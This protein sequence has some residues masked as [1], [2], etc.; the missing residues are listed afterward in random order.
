MRAYGTQSPILGEG[1]MSII[2]QLHLKRRHNNVTNPLSNAHKANT[3]SCIKVDSCK[4]KMET[5]PFLKDFV[6]EL[7]TKNLGKSPNFLTI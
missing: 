7:N 4:K 6:P 3:E 1:K 5:E 2:V